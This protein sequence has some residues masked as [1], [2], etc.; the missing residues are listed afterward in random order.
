MIRLKEYQKQV[1]AEFKGYLGQVRKYREDDPHIV[2]FDKIQKAIGS[3]K[4]Y[5]TECGVSCP[6]VCIKI[7]TGGGKTIVACH[8]LD[9][10]YQEYLRR[11]RDT[12]I[13]VWLMPTETIR[14]QTLN[15]LKNPEHPYRQALDKFFAEKVLV[16]NLKEALSIKRADVRE[17]LCIIVATFS[18]FRISDME[19]RKV[20]EQNGNLMEHFKDTPSAGL[21]LDD[22]GNVTESLV[23]VIRMSEPIVMLDESHGAQTKLSYKMLRDLN[24][25]FIVE[26]TATPRPSS[27]ILCNVTGKRLKDENMIKIPILVHNVAQ[28][29]E[30]LRQGIEK[31]NHLERQAKRE[32]E[33][34][35]P[36][37]LIQ[38]EQEKPDPKKL[39]VDM[40]RQWLLGE[41]IPGDQ[42][43]VETGKSKELAGV[44]LYSKSCEIRYIVTVRALKEGWDNAFA[45]VLISV[46]NSESKISVEQTIGRILRLPHQKKKQVDDLNQSY[47]FASSL[48]YANVAKVVQEGLIKNG[49]AKDD[50]KHP[51]D[52]NVTIDSFERAVFDYKI[53]IPCI[54]IKD[55][56]AHRLDFFTD[57]LGNDFKLE[58]QDAQLDFASS[59][60]KNRMEKIDIREG[61]KLERYEQTMLEIQYRG[62][63]FSKD[64]LLG[65]LDRK[66]RLAE[67][68]QS[69]KRKYLKR[70]ID[71]MMEKEQIPLHE[72]S[73]NR[74]D[75]LDAIRAH[76]RQLE[77]YLAKQNF[78]RLREAK[79][80]STDKTYSPG[81]VMEISSIS[82]ER[83]NLHLFERAGAMN[84]EE[85][86]FVR[87]I[88]TLSN[89][90]WW[91]RNIEKRDFFIQGWSRQRFYPDFILKT[92]SGTIVIVEYKGEYLLT[93]EDTKYKE[94]I[95][96]EWA[97][98][99]GRG[100]EFYLVDKSNLAQTVKHIASL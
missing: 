74:Y 44:D 27:N 16:Y 13:V 84:S 53:K 64:D 66:L 81:L 94:D 72:L 92:K 20:Y 2:I 33:Y 46:A 86:E 70:V 26:Y 45:Y 59:F 50:F 48:N 42:I 80:L 41:K 11:E 47:V 29:Q 10:L 38:A 75:L 8:I 60:S 78:L 24:P 55:K 31:R 63:D 89:T 68:A 28:W 36:I 57:L 71:H 14:T 43:A 34:L 52:K 23:N 90:R 69:D 61:D 67:Y 5:N 65:W 76:I 12:G 85:L 87:Q 98:L 3:T 30:T 17:N 79:K 95:G 1:I 93:G 83:F 40:I 9:S 96:K 35:R 19:G 56:K 88:D 7:P 54:T 73:N 25:S 62:E 4:Y 15:A 100:H 18:T 32:G 58:T 77:S 99:A 6:I 51:S 91:Y 37:A 21:L 97:K 49:Y 39:Y 82:E 22:N